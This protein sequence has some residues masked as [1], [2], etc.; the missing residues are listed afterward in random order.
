MKEIYYVEDD[1]AVAG[2]VADYL[3][4]REFRVTLLFGLDE[5]RKTLH[6][7]KPDLLL[8]DWNMPDGQGEHLCRF[9]RSRWSDLPV[10]FLTV[11]GDAEKMADRLC[12][13]AG[14]Y[15][16]KPFELEALYSRV[17]ALLRHSKSMADEVLVCDEISVNVSRAVVFCEGE[18]VP[19]SQVEYQLL[20]ALMTN[21]GKTMSRERL[22]REVWDNKGSYV[23]D[24]TLTVT[25]KRLRLRLGQPSCLK[26]IRSFGYRMEETS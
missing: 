19:V 7:Q 25:M 15:V 21:R 4:R 24:N 18:E 10:I 2:L 20:M 3:E 17:Q 14:D 22:L 5:A 12:S 16:V 26:T 8:L 11:R 13:G 23:N 1:T 9:V 6:R